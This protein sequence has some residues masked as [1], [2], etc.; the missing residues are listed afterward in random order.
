MKKLLLLFMAFGLILTANAQTTTACGTDSIILQVDNYVNGVIEWEESLDS[1]VWITIPGETGETYKFFPTETKYYRT[2]VIT[3]E[4]DPLCSDVTLIQMPPKSYAGSDREIGGNISKLLGSIELGAS[5]QW[6]ILEGTGGSLGDKANPYSEFTGEYGQNYKLIWTVTNGCGQSTDTMSIAFEE[7]KAKDNF[8]V[9]D[10]TDQILSDSAER[11]TGIYRIQFSDPTIV[12]TDTMMLIGMREDISFIV[13]IL[14]FTK[15]NEVY[16][17]TTAVGGLEDIIQ[18]GTVNVGDAVNESIVTDGKKKSAKFPTRETLKTYAQNTGQQVIYSG[19]FYDREGNRRNISRK[20]SNSKGIML[21][22]PDMDLFSSPDG[23]IS[24]SIENAYVRFEPNFVCDFKIGFFTIKNIKIGLD[25]GEFEY[26]YKLTVQATAAKELSK[27]KDLLELTNNTVFM[28]G[29]VPV[30]VASSFVI[31]ASASLTASAILTVVQEKNYQKNFTA[32]LQGETLKKAQFVSFSSSKSTSETSYNVQGRLDAEFSIGPEISVELYKVVGP[33][34]ELPLTLAVGICVNKDLNWDASASLGIEGNLGIRAHLGS[35]SLFD[36]KHTLFRAELMKPLILPYK[37]A[38]RS[39]NSQKGLQGSLISNPIS[40]KVTSNYGFGVPLIPVRFSLDDGNGSITKDVRF[41]DKDGMVKVDDW[42]LGTNP[43]SQLNISVLNCDNDDIDVNSPLTVYAYTIFNCAN[44]NLA[45]SLDRTESA[46][47]PIVTGGT[48]PYTYSTDGANYSSSVPEFSNTVEGNFMVYVKDNNSCNINKNITVVKQDPC[49]IS[50]LFI[51]VY[52]EANTFQLTGIGGKAP[53]QF[54][55]DNNAN[56]A[57]SALLSGLSEGEHNVYI[58]DANN[59][60]NSDSINVEHLDANAINAVQPKNGAHYCT[61]SNLYFQWQSG[62]YAENQKYDIYLSKDG[63]AYSVIAQDLSDVNYT[64]SAN[65]DY[66]SLYHWKLVVKDQNGV[67]KDFREFSFTTMSDPSIVAQ[68]PTQIQPLNNDLVNTTTTL[69]W[70]KQSGDF[71]YDVF[72]DNNLAAYSLNTDSLN[73]SNLTPSMGYSWKVKIKN[74]VSGEALESPV[75]N[76]EVKSLLPTLTTNVVLNIFDEKAVCGGTINSEG[77]APV[78][79]RGVC[80]SKFENPT[81][82]SSHLDLGLGA[83]FFEGTISGLEPETDY[84]V[85]AYAIN[86]N[87]LVYGNQESFKTTPPMPVDGDGNIYSTVVIGTQRWMKENLKTTKYN[88]GTTIGTAWDTTASYAWYY[89]DINYKEERGALY[90]WYAVDTISNGN[91]N[92][93]PVGWHVP[94]QAEYQTLIDYLG[95]SYVAGGKMKEPG[96]EH[97]NSPNNGATNESGFTAIPGGILRNGLFEYINSDGYLWINSKS[98]PYG[99][100]TFN[101][102]Y[103]NLFSN[104]ASVGM[105]NFPNWAGMSV[106]CIKD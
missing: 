78:T 30:L 24:A 48:A 67:E 43:E 61:A 5:G 26:N 22:I 55:M 80:W 79:S 86:S 81:M 95:G 94:I 33:Y 98:D 31:K 39:G 85:R 54:S 6:S 10:N 63:A 88:D 97:W 21:S 46:I 34:F 59:C 72:I 100:G 102:I 49:T 8:I 77:L 90:N 35:W 42:T 71:K 66:A 41:T 57:E 99:F 1:I 23:A 9:V 82:D 27:E 18:S 19:D 32:L 15:E 51:D 101:P 52:S 3:S 40:L 103:I 16:V 58:M 104:S 74:V 84:F 20:S 45:I 12:P 73:I 25:N 17:F 75:W 83:G 11:A 29:P 87:G 47:I 89:N 4:C 69:K 53:Y 14:S 76:F 105:T 28:V 50:P 92:V 60:I 38:L 37:I 56:F 36:I 64:Y 91:K 65:L 93:C 96:F 70:Q 44:N 7:I 68:I 62:L 106:R 13:K 2:T